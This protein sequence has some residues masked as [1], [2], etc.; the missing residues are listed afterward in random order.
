M[1]WLYKSLNRRFAAA[2]ALG[3]VVSSLFFLLLFVGLYRGQLERERTNTAARVSELVQHS[4]EY[5]VSRRDVEGLR[6]MVE[7]MAQAEGIRAVKIA[8][9]TGQV[10]FSSN[11]A[12]LG[13]H[14]GALADDLQLPVTLFLDRGDDP[15][16]LRIISSVREI[17]HGDV[18]AE[19]SPGRPLSGTLYVD[20][21]AAQIE[22]QA[23]T[24][25]LLLMGSGALIV[26]INIA[27][28][29][30]FI[31]R[32]VLRP[33]ERLSAV[34]Q[35]LSDGELGARITLEGRD[36]FS[37][38]AHRFNRM[39]ESLQ[40]KFKELEEKDSYLQA[41]VD[42]IPDG[43]R[44]IDE[45]YRVVLSNATY[46][47]QHGFGESDPIPDRCYA[48]SHGRDT[49]CPGTL[50]LCTLQEVLATDQPLRVVHRHLTADGVGLDVEVYAAPMRIDGRNGPRRMMVES[51][52]NLQQQVKFSH[53]Q[54]L[55]ELGRLAAGVAHEIHNPL[56]SIRLALHAA[57]RINSSV[58][59]NPAK[60]SEYLDL[61]DGEIS[62]CE[63]VTGRLLKLSIPPSSQ[64]ELVV[65]DQVVDETLKLLCWEADDRGIEVDFTVDGGPLRVLATDSDLRMMALNLAQNACHAMPGGGLLSVRCKRDGDRVS[66]SF[67]DTGVGIEPGDQQRIFEPFFSRRAD[68]VRGTGLGLS[69]TKTIVEGHGGSIR[70]NSTSGSGSCFAV[71]FPDADVAPPEHCV[72][73]IDQ[74][75][76][77]G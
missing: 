45:D 58:P 19:V 20:F 29:W 23:R 49:P 42:A 46:R 62:K 44:V 48:A 15:D 74:P 27:G 65:L 3:L 55:S 22:K 41:L 34:S 17:Q 13:T 64:R 56:S 10:R 57:E 16:V 33:V 61:V 28:G 2:T 43:V 5:L 37:T 50:T 8:D 7:R 76:L 67:E 26:L 63:Q 6:E 72:P 70:L 75:L 1:H 39:A 24:T 18:A 36:E 40:Q 35:H 68:G 66:V 21:D 32:Y 14:L 51:I 53:E 31:R 59:A 73:G 60:L 77:L 52:R 12:D 25:T 38:L 69:I 47:E 9:P 54:R 11:P 30:W 4:L 71:S